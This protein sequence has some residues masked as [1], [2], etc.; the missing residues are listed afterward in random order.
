MQVFTLG[1]S[2]SGQ[3][4]TDAGGEIS[5]GGSWRETTGIDAE[6]ILSDDPGTFFR[7]DY[8]FF[9]AWTDNSA[10]SHG[11]PVMPNRWLNVIFA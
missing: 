3:A 2:F 11:F 9:F 1:G 4:M 8:G 10:A 5:N 6:V 7:T